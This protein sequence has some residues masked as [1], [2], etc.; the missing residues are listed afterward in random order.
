MKMSEENRAYSPLKQKL[1]I[2]HYEN[3]YQKRVQNLERKEAEIAA[4][5]RR[6]RKMKEDESE[7]IKEKA[8]EIANP[9]ILNVKRKCEDAKIKEPSCICVGEYNPYC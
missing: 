8:E 5:K 3:A 2:I 6:V 4:E 1:R 9:K 7:L